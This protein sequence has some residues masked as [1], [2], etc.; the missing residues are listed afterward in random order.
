MIFVFG[1]NLAGI[2]GAGAARVAYRDHGAVWGS[3]IGMNGNSYALPTKGWNIETLPLDEVGA[4][5]SVFM[6]IARENPD[7]TFQVTQV[8][9]GLAGFTPGQIAP[10]FVCAPD[11]CQFDSAW[12]EW[13]PGRTFWGTVP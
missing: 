3:G 11:N 9:C 12:A 2:H 7:L 4:H 5:V 6:Q 8:G 13:L 10:M 1:S